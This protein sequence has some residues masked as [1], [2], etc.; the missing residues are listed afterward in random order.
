[1]DRIALA[2]NDTC[3]EVSAPNEGQ[4]G[5]DPVRYPTSESASLA[6]LD[7]HLSHLA[8][9]AVAPVRRQKDTDDRIHRAMRPGHA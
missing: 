6:V 9:A 5:S 8:A 1:M 4:L 2:T 3:R 7:A